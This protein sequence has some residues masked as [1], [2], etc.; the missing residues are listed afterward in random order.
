M[1]AVAR[2][3]ALRR[4]A[5]LPVHAAF[6]SGFR[7]DDRN[8][9]I[10]GHARVHRRFK[11]DDRSLR[12]ILTDRAGRGFYWTQVGRR[13][14]IDRSWHCHNDELRLPQTCRICGKINC[15]VPDRIANLIGRVDPVAVFL[16]APFIDVKA[17]DLNMFR[18]LN[19]NRHT[20]IAKANQRQLFPS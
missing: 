9:N 18:K 19:R 8:A 10:L 20:H 4:I 14:R 3:D 6:E 15:R 1:Y 11:D 2:V 17:N 16:D 13:I 12:Q 7:F 5:D